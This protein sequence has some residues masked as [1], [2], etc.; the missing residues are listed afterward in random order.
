MKKLIL[1]STSP[2]RKELLKNLGLTF[3]IEKP[4][5]DEKSDKKEFTYDYIKTIAKN[6]CQSVLNIIKES[7]IVISADTLVICNNEIMGKPKNYDEAYKMLNTLNNKTHKVVTAICIGDTDTKEKIINTETSEV[8]FNKITDEEIKDYI[9]K[10]KP[11]D[12]AG[13]YGIQELPEGFI[14]EIKGEYDNIVGLPTKM[15]IK[16]MKEI[17]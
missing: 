17:V 9:N 11:Y 1:A 12:K 4:L 10:F 16:M 3:E 15:L 8:T 6:K 13:S 7:A 2:R 5:Y 14:K